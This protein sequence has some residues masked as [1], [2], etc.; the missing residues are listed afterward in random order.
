MGTVYNIFGSV[1]FA[2][3]V[4]DDLVCIVAM[5]LKIIQEPKFSNSTSAQ[6]ALDHLRKRM[7][8]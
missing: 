1:I 5:Y 4:V 3:F 2:L 8:R 7:H 6:R